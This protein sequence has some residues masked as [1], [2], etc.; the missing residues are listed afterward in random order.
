MSIDWDQLGQQWF[1]RIVEALINH[2]YRHA[3]V[4][5]VNGRGGDGGI[6]IEVREGNRLRIFQLK[7]FP[8][9]FSGGFAQTRRAQI[10]KSYN[11]MLN[12]EPYEWILVVPNNLTPT[13][14]AFVEGLSKGA[15]TPRWRIID[16]KELDD[17]LIEFPQVDRW[18]QRNVTNQL[19]EDAELFKTERASLLNPDDLGDRVGGLGEL[20]DS[21]DLDWTFDFQRAGNTVSQVLRA[22]HP[23]AHLTS[24]VS[25]NFRTRFGPEHA[26][27]EQRYQRKIGFG[28]ADAVELPP[29]VVRDI[30]ITGPPSVARRFDSA[31]VAIG[32]G[33]VA[34][35]VGL[36]LEMR[37]SDED[38]IL[39]ASHEGRI[40]HAG[41]G[42]H[43]HSVKAAFC[44]GHLRVELT[45]ARSLEEQVV[46]PAAQV[47]HGIGGLQPRVVAEVL[48]FVRQMRSAHKLEVFINGDFTFSV[49]SDIDTPVDEEELILEEFASDLDI[50]Q[51]HCGQHFA[52]PD[53][54]SGED[55]V[56]IRIA[57]IVIKGGVVAAHNI[58]TVTWTWQGEG[59]PGLRAL[60][61]APEMPVLFGHANHTVKLGNR[62]LPIGPIWVFHHAATAI[63]PAKA[64]AALDSGE[65][66]G[67][68]IKFR[69]AHDPLFLIASAERPHD[70]LQDQP[71]TLWQL[72]GITQPRQDPRPVDPDT[73]G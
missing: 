36:P 54:V 10:R 59:V 66:D 53:T 14:R 33:G 4:I 28:T 8:E 18:A 50:V 35:I 71:E 32:A 23:R 40:A 3:I 19:R 58:D 31:S 46:P 12:E 73:A 27:L 64:I 70:Q 69:L 26:E 2:R 56:A 63:D 9:G 67:L 13:E 38:G 52:F 6:D 16:R 48:G 22:Q 30:E 1:D 68:Q 45:F 5:A 17:L 24:P 41:A 60:L 51:Q 57:R 43:G 11:S 65:V 20:V 39:I 15:T 49:I 72:R 34:P 42:P 21:A 25:F 62:V 55:R 47:S 37:F 61:E 44:D 7:Y 29:E